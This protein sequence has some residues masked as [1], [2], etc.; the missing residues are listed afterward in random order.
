MF[1]RLLNILWFV[2]LLSG[3]LHAEVEIPVEDLP[4]ESMKPSNSWE[5]INFQRRLEIANTYTSE[6]LNI[7]A[8]N[9]AS[10]PVN[11]YF[12]PISEDVFSTISMFNA[13]LKGRTTLLSTLVMPFAFE[14]PG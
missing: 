7:V 10:E 1:L 13:G 4:N 2:S 6:T 11:Q 14:T 12:I 5:N 8:V 3:V 9:I